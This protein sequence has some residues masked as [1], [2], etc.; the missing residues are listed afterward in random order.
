MARGTSF[1]AGWRDVSLSSCVG[2]SWGSRSKGSCLCEL[3]NFLT[4]NKLALW[5]S[6]VH[7]LSLSYLWL[8]QV[9]NAPCHQSWCELNLSERTCQH[10]APNCYLEVRL[11]E[12]FIRLQLFPKI[13][14]CCCGFLGL[15]LAEVTEIGPS[16][17]NWKDAGS[18]VQLW[19]TSDLRFF[20]LY[21]TS[22][23]IY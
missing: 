7:I 6:A 15:V 17:N 1:L 8:V 23:Q 4:N 14:C 10:I 19:E 13:C 3:S 21:S 16:Q 20:C 9:T 11:A 18:S 2:L 22:I 5:C 12:Y